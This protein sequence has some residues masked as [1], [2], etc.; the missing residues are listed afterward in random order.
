MLPL[1]T[2]CLE[3]RWPLLTVL[4]LVLEDLAPA[5]LAQAVVHTPTLAPSP[6]EV[7]RASHH[8][9]QPRVPLLFRSLVVPLTLRMGSTRT[10][11]FQVLRGP[12]MISLRISFLHRH[13]RVAVS[14]NLSSFKPATVSLSPDIL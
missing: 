7:S 13:R 5:L 4:E 10:S 1:R 9:A 14:N 11:T 6:Q 2:P 12:S 8:Q 3:S